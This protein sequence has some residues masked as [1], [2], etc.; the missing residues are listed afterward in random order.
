MGRAMFYHMTRKPV[1]ATAPP[2]LERARREGWRVIVR[3][4]TPQRAEWF[5]EALW[6]YGDVSFLPHGVAGGPHDADQPILLT[7]DPA[8]VTRSQAQALMVIDGAPVDPAETRD[9]ER[10]FIL[11]DGG[12]P[13]AVQQARGQWTAMKNAGVHAQYWSEESGRWEMNSE[14]GAPEADDGG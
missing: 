4:G 8:P 6:L 12:E 14:T 10:V 1:Q 11:F 9:L 5:D 3:A 13:A 7:S 2:L